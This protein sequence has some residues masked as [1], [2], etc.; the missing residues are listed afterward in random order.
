MDAIWAAEMV[1]ESSHLVGHSYGG[2]IALAAAALR[3]TVVRSLTLIEA[4]VFSAAETIQTSRPHERSRRG[5]LPPSS[6][7]SKD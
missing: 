2:L 7:R 6:S 4:P 5:S 3:P 1:G